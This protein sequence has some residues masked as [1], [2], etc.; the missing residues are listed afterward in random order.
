MKLSVSGF[1]ATDDGLG[2]CK[3]TQLTDLSALGCKR[4]IT[5]LRLFISDPRLDS[6]GSWQDHQD[7]DRNNDTEKFG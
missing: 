3:V 4:I 1:I 6:L 2:G 5:L 7:G